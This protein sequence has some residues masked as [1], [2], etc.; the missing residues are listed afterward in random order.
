MEQEL[1]KF[2]KRTF[3]L[4]LYSRKWGIKWKN[5][6]FLLYQKYSVYKNYM[7]SMQ[8]DIYVADIKRIFK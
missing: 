2:V 7:Y 1:E 8:I 5:I 4:I 6:I 3:S